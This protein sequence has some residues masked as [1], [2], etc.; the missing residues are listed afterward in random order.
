MGCCQI[1]YKGVMVSGVFECGKGRGM[2]KTGTGIFLFSLRLLSLFGMRIFLKTPRLGMRS[3]FRIMIP[4]TSK[5]HY[6]NRKLLAG[7]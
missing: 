2:G 1:D 6:L 5:C 3:Y 4:K 7:H